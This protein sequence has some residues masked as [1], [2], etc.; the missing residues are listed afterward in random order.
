MYMEGQLA[1]QKPSPTHMLLARQSP[2]RDCP[3]MGYMSS[4]YGQ[5]SEISDPDWVEFE[6]LLSELARLAKSEMSFQRVAQSLLDQT[7]H[8][9]AAVGGAVWLGQWPAPLRLECELNSQSLERDPELNFHEQ[10]LEQA[11]REGDTLVVP[12][13]GTTIDSR[14]LPN[15]TDYT[16]LIGPL[17]VDQD[18]VG[19]I[20]LIQRPTASAA[21][22][23]GNR[24]LLA[25][26]CEL[27]ADH[28]RRHELRQLRDQRLQTQQF[29]AFLAR[30]HG[31]LDLPA[32]A[33]EVANVGRQLIDC[34]RVTV[35]IRKGHAFRLLA[36]SGVDSINRRS[37]AVRRLED[38]A[39]R[40]ARAGETVWYQGDEDEPLAPQILEAL[41]LYADE[42]HPRAIGLIPLT[43]SKTSPR[44]A[45]PPVFGV[46]IVEHFQSV[47]DELARGRAIRVAEN[48]SSSLLNA[49]RHEALPT[50]PFVRYFRQPLG[51]PSVRRSTL[52]IVLAAAALAIS[53]LFIPMDFNVHAQGELQ[54]RQLQHVFAPFEAQVAAIRV[55]H[56]EMVK[57]NDLLLELR[58]PD[59]ELESQRIQ[60]EFDVTQ[61]RIL[62][63]ESSLLEDDRSKDEDTLRLNQL[64]GEREEL[65]QLLASQQEQLDLL[66]LERKKLAVLSPIDGQ[67]LTWDLEQTLADRPVQRGQLLLSVANVHGPWVAELEIPDD[68]VG[69]VLSSREAQES[70]NASFQLATKRGVDY[71][72]VIHR[73]AARTEPT[74]DDR[75]V[76]HAMMEVDEAA[77][78]ELRPGATIYA[79]IHCGRRSVAFV[80]FHGAVEAVVN[81]FR[82]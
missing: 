42:A 27:A 53:S 75:A 77:I 37:N 45:R 63:I 30:I 33:F 34:D 74:D 2:L 65:M 46:L 64:A 39:S 5:P 21:A 73:L 41:R 29:E 76:V 66:S 49:L 14:I 59:L 47:F 43:D 10:L 54:P 52:V 44:G 8:L 61:R 6:S 68:Q 71:R 78:G 18:V 50:L 57:A 24:R 13:G 16:L 36:V 22:I 51:Q 9:L 55:K 19:L 40:V 82:F 35:A 79:K 60:G 32:V 17:K 62:N 12:P 80:L 31:S 25:L 26:V 20:E 48:S 1:A 4:T 11:R 58:S 28:L 72:G 38:L 23:R 70:M 7:V 56:G 67:V 81:W 15:P 69:H 3:I